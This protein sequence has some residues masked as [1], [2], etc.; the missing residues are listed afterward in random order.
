MSGLS[1]SQLLAV[2]ECGIGQL[3]V[4]RAL[5]LLAA[6]FPDES[7]GDLADLS[8]G[9]RDGRLLK[10]REQLFGSQLTSLTDCPACGERVETSFRVS[11]ILLEQDSLAGTEGLV[12]DLD[13]YHLRFRP[14]NSRDLLLSVERPY[15]T[16]PELRASG[17][18][19]ERRQVLAEQCVL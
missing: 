14:P 16:T 7:L 1:A 5:S 4:Q 12:T 6:A 18:R 13:G 10:L 19:E 15:S 2:W 9:Q 3:P 17:N 11:D 8:I